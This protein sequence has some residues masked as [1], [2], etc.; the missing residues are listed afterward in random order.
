[1][2]KIRK[3]ARLSV[4]RASG[5][6]ALA[7]LMVMMGTA[8]DPVTSFKLGAVGMLIL[9]AVLLYRGESY[10][11]HIRRISDTEVWLMLRENERPPK[12]IARG[13]IV[14]AMRAELLQK[15]GWAVLVALV[16]LGISSLITIAAL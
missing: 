4:M 8:H 5:F 16:F 2:S 14:A 1:M 7:I 10:H 12:D 3:L 15:S 6:S 13:L 9:S 11:R